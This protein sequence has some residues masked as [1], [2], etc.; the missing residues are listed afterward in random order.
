MNYPEGNQYPSGEIE[1]EFATGESE[2]YV[3]LDDGIISFNI[4]TEDDE[5]DY[6]PTVSEGVIPVDLIPAF[7]SAL[8]AAKR[9]W[10]TA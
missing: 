5:L 10:E 7:T 9:K 8:L 4:A 6:L 3:N 1:W 2:G